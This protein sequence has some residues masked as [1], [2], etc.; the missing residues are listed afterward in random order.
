[1]IA[2]SKLQDIHSVNIYG[3]YHVLSN[4]PGPMDIRF[5]LKEKEAT[6][7]ENIT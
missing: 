4:V 1:M 2:F 6:L 5:F 3:S 7:R